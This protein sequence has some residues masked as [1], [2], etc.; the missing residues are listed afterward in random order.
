MDKITGKIILDLFDPNKLFYQETCEHWCFLS[1]QSLK[2]TILTIFHNIIITTNIN[3]RFNNIIPN[4]S[5]ITVYR[6][7][8]TRKS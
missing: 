1:G 5:E 6:F 8:S 7:S 3:N 2:D 4:S